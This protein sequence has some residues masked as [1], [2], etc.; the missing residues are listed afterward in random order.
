MFYPTPPNVPNRE[1]LS[2]SDE[3]KAAA[4]KATR[5]LIFN[6]ILI[7]SKFQQGVNPPRPTSLIKR[8]KRHSLAAFYE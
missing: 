8:N 4:N 5:V 1:S 3:K 7:V 2:M 6:S